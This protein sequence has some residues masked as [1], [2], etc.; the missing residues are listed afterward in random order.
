M[1]DFIRTGSIGLDIALGGGWPVGGLHEVWGDSGSGKTVLALSTVESVV[2]ARMGHVLWIDTVDGVPHMDKAPKVIVGRPRSA[3]QA[4]TMAE[5]A[6]HW[7]NINLIVIDSANNLVRQAELDGDPGYVPHPQREYK[8]ELSRL[9]RL[10]K[11]WNK[12]ALFLSQPRD[13]AREP[14]RGTGISEKAMW[15]VNLHPDVVHQDG[16]RLIRATTKHV[17]SRMTRFD[18]ASFRIVPGRGIDRETEYIRLGEQ[19]GLIE[20]HGSWLDAG[21]VH[22]QGTEGMAL[23]LRRNPQRLQE[24]DTEIR[25]MACV[26]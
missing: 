11:G 16:T 15:R 4:F 19:F 22:R 8:T 21:Q 5:Q 6:C 25:T 13:M 26:A 7:E 2:R 12:T 17:P 20:R 14:I 18:A 24:L 10:L 9:K 3:E 23:W 1:P